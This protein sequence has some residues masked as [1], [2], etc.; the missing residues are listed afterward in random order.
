MNA[1]FLSLSLFAPSTSNTQYTC[2]YH[3]HPEITSQLHE[4]VPNN[5]LLQR[6]KSVALSRETI[7]W[8]DVQLTLVCSMMRPSTHFYSIPLHLRPSLSLTGLISNSFIVLVFF[9]LLLLILLHH[10][11]CLYRLFSRP[12]SA[13]VAAA[14]PSPSPPPAHRPPA[15]SCSRTSV[16]APHPQAP[17]TRDTSGCASATRQCRHRGRRAGTVGNG[18]GHPSGSRTYRLRTRTGSWRISLKRSC[19]PPPFPILSL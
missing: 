12:L 3:H 9:H 5:K 7:T 10:L 15:I 4:N 8:I 17:S 11:L 18:S 16:A 13:P 6:T 1:L 19:S 14:S 2:C